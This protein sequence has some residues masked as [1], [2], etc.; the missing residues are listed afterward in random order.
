[1]EG[2]CP[3]CG[4]SPL[5]IDEPGPWAD[6]IAR[7]GEADALA[8]IARIDND[9]EIETLFRVEFMGPNRDS[10]LTALHERYWQV[11]DVPPEAT[12]RGR[13]MTL[14]E[15]RAAW[16][17]ELENEDSRRMYLRLCEVV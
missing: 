16:A 8:L 5:L 3:A 13:A 10:I 7:M 1:M 2:E 14:P 11:V 17:R 9:G 12:A 4:R 15:L 6:N